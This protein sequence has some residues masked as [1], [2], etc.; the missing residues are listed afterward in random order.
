M[1]RI[2]SLDVR[3]N[4]QALSCSILSRNRVVAIVALRGLLVTDQD[5]PYPVLLPA[6]A[7]HDPV[8]AVAGQAE[9]GVD[10]PVR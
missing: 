8:D 10:A 6:Q 7:L 4:D 3:M 1:M 2:L 9:H 5:E